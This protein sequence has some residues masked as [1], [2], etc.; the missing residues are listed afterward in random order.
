MIRDQAS[1]SLPDYLDGKIAASIGRAI[2]PDP[3]DVAGFQTFL[4]RYKQGLAIEAE[5]VKTL[6]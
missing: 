5:A 2:A 3:R 1:E 6:R 4:E